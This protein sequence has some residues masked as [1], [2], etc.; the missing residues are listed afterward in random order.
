MLTQD[1]DGCGTAL[2]DA[3]REGY[4]DDNFKLRAVDSCHVRMPEKESPSESNNNL[5][6]RSSQ[7]TMVANNTY[8]LHIQ[9]LLPHHPPIPFT[10]TYILL[11]SK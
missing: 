7:D 5:K 4:F 10:R 3:A 2:H 11:C 6:E 9:V 8:D 1:A